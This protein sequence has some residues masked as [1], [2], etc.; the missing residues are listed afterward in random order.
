M[1]ADGQALLAALRADGLDPAQI[2]RRDADDSQRLANGE[3]A[4]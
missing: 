4:A 3:V 1:S 2:A